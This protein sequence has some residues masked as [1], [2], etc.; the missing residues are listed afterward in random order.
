[1]TEFL[2]SH[3]E[4]VRSSR[5]V[6]SFLSNRGNPDASSWRYI[7]SST[8]RGQHVNVAVAACVFAAV[9]YGSGAVLQSFGAQT[10][11]VSNVLG[12]AAMVRQKW[13]L[14]GLACDLV[15]WLLTIYAVNHLPLFAVHTT[16]ASS[17]AVTVVLARVFL[18]TPLRRSDAVAVAIVLTGLVLVGIAAESAPESGGDNFARTA[19]A[20]GVIPA[21]ALALVALRSTRPIGAAIT[22]GGLFSF[23]AASVRTLDLGDGAV[24]LLGQPT[25]WAVPLYLGAGLI[26][27]A[28]SLQTG[29]VGPVTAALWATEVL[30]GSATGY[31]LFGDRV[32]PGTFVWAMIGMVLAVGATVRLAFSPSHHGAT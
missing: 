20:V 13:Y 17:V 31:V 1:V 32:R 30:V 11:G 25:A 24:G 6:R 15:G 21:A 16:L 3:H 14:A 8:T 18:R 9:A 7:S 22:A 4:R 27:H 10:S 12:L 23:G 28:R 29:T 19:L 2:R 5:P 26:V